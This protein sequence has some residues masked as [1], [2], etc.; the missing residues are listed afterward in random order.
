MD[1]HLKE[2]RHGWKQ[3]VPPVILCAGNWLT[4]PSKKITDIAQRRNARLLSL[5]LICLFLLFLSTNLVYLFTIEG[6]RFPPADLMGYGFLLV[7][8]IISR[9]RFTRIGV[10]LLLIMFPMNVFSNV[11]SGT[12]MNLTAT[13]SFLLPSYVLAAIFI[14]PWGTALYGYA[15]NLA[16]FLLP[17]LAP[18]IVPDYSQILGTL[19]GGVIV[20][21]LCIIMIINRDQIERD[22]QG[23]LRT[24]YDNTLEGW[25]HA[26]E[27]RDKETEGHCLRVTELALRLA[28]ACGVGG[29]EIENIYRG[30]LLHDIGKMAIPDSILTKKSRLSDE[31]WKVMKTHPR[32]AQELLADIP[33]LQSALA[34]PAYH[35]EWWNGNGYPF[36]LRSAKIPLAARIFAVADVWDALLSDRPYR[37]A[38]T[39]E[40]ALQYIK[41]QRGKQFDPK[42]VDAFLAL[43][44]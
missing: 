11:F 28:H 22:R 41:D 13:L 33:F 5:F 23:E 8:Y 14:K 12:T 38:W 34:I 2:S 31:E 40:H 10:A 15:C 17:I 18:R 26:L 42:V 44:P 29:N 4:G 21:T 32:I 35:H 25:S 43:N 7:T 36:H 6:Y 30:S 24:A 27:I 16:I 37:K 19:A 3:K 39:R 20:V 9:T 1:Y